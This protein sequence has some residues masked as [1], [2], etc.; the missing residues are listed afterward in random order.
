MNVSKTEEKVQPLRS[1]SSSM[2]KLPTH[3]KPKPIDTS[4]ERKKVT[5]LSFINDS[6]EGRR[7]PV[8]ITG[9]SPK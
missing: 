1:R 4:L 8:K 7:I 5:N 3:P 9:G 6:M 2:K